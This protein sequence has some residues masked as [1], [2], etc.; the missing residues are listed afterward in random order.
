MKEFDGYRAVY[1]APRQWHEVQPHDG[2]RCVLVAYSPRTTNLGGKDRRELQNLGFNVKELNQESEPLMGLFRKGAQETV[3]KAMTV[4]NE[5]NQ[6]LIE[7]LQERAYALRMLLEEEQA[8]NE[9]LRE[10]GAAVYEEA[11]AISRTVGDMI[12][13]V[14]GTL[15]EK[16]EEIVRLCG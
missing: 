9:D 1:F 5:A 6:Q 14:E 4:L 3:Q 15:K 7:D 10:A 11:A 13:N 2:D 8:L 16:D 12:R